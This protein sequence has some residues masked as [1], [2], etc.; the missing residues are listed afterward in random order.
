MF[1]DSGPADAGLGDPVAGVAPIAPALDSQ[2]ASL[3]AQSALQTGLPSGNLDLGMGQV[4]VPGMAPG[5]VPADLGAIPAGKATG[6][7]KAFNIEKGYGFIA[8]DGGG[9]DFFVHASSLQDGNALAVG[10]RVIFKPSFD[11]AKMKPVAQEVTGAYTDPRR[12]TGVAAGLPPS[13]PMGVAQGLT[14]PAAGAQSAFPWMATP[15]A[16]STPAVLPPGKVGGSVKA[17]NVERGFGFI[18][19]DGGEDHF[20]HAANLL[21]GNALA[22]GARVTFVPDFDHQ[23][24]KPIAKQVGGGYYDPNRPVPSAEAKAALGMPPTA[25][26]QNFASP[27]AAPAVQ[28]GIMPYAPGPP[29]GEAP[30][31]PGKVG[32]T[33]KAFNVE[34]GFGF[35]AM[36]GGEDHFVHAANLLEGNALAVG[37]RVTFAPNFDHQKGKPI[38]KEV[39]GGYYDPNRPVPSAEAQQ[40][41]GMPP[42]ARSQNGMIAQNTG[43]ALFEPAPPPGK[44][45]GT[46]KAFNIEKGFGFIAPDGGGEDHFVHAQKLL[47]GNCLRVGGRVFFAPAY[48]HQKMKPIA[49]QVTG[50]YIDPARP[51]PANPQGAGGMGGGAAAGGFAPPMQLYQQQQPQQQP[52]MGAMGG[53]GGM[54]GMGAMGGMAAM[55]EAVQA[56]ILALQQQQAQLQA[57]Y[58]P[59]SMPGMGAMAGGMDMSQFGQLGQMGQLGQAGQMQG[60]YAQQ[61]QQQ[62]QQQPQQPQPQP[63]QG[64]QVQ[65]CQQQPAAQQ[66]QYPGY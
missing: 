30:P 46:V 59:L 15:A 21:D 24:G 3:M 47:E 42:T 13:T 53:M 48:D 23:K 25:R 50:G 35:I 64:P 31:P 12:V 60:M 36:D 43:P 28:P 27:P 44:L 61:Q 62:Q 55:P 57:M 51:A 7:V 33:V 52:A 10:G 26:S 41:L 17:F 20:V 66:M 16:V 2:T 40:A 32:G 65:G 39:S 45:A 37:A 58:A 4:Q 29:P 22:V 1:S 63:P 14:P 38:A 49:E 19:M 56:Q 6:N 5:A 8:P 18:A 54:G 34:R 11:P 9:E